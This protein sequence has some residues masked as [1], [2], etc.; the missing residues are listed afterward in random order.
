MFQWPSSVSTAVAI[1]AS[2]GHPCHSTRLIQRSLPKLV[3]YSAH[4]YY[5]RKKHAT[6]RVRCR[7][8]H[9]HDT[10]SLKS[11]HIYSRA[12]NTWRRNFQ[13]GWP[14]FIAGLLSENFHLPTFPIESPRIIN[15]KSFI[16]SLSRSS[17]SPRQI[18]SKLLA[19]HT[20]VWL[21]VSVDSLKS[22]ESTFSFIDHRTVVL[23]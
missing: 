5:L 10:G 11:S 1:L 7:P 3:V 19:C 22:R 17:L 16:E 15:F 4:S 21:F 12:F 13:S 6:S 9:H 2:E 20:R 23:Y 14:I 8:R 18:L